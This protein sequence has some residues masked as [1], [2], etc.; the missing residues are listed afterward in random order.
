MPRLAW[1]GLALSTACWAMPARADLGE[2]VRTHQHAR[3]L[4]GRVL[5]LKPRLLERGERLPLP[6]PPELLD[7]K[8]ASCVTV[9][10]LGVPETHFVVRFSSLDPSAPS[11]A[12]PEA[13]VA[14]AMDITRCGSG[15]PFLA[16]IVLEMRSP[17]GVLETLISAAPAGVPRL[18]ETLPGRDPGVDLALGDPG[19]R[20]GLPPLVQ[21][22]AR[23]SA[24][25]KRE[26]ALSFE[27]EPLSARDDGSGAR[28]LS[29]TAGCHQLRLLAE[30]ALP[31]AEPQVD[32][33]LE[34]VNAESGARV[35]VDRSDDPDGALSW[36]VGETVPVELRFVGAR[37][38]SPLTLTHARWE[39]PAGLPQAWG[40]E[41]RAALGRV[42]WAEHLSL[43]S[44]PVYESLGVQGSSALP[45][46]VEPDACYTALLVPLRGEVRALSLSAFVRSPGETARG[47]SDTDGTAVSFCARGATRAT[48]EV[49][50]QGSS[51]SW[52]LALWETG[53]AVI[54]S[55]AP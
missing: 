10:V 32:L 17:R 12:Y 1:L 39:L 13:S 9:A 5:R 21:R 23:L 48:L 27:H 25:A 54:G 45:I 40:A 42:A 22:L 35:A 52:L 8:G 37:P 24:R 55:A 15:K 3:A 14:G 36:C 29:L 2:D 43:P 46:E 11:T 38:S 31:G 26:A 16:G 53:R 44:A 51:L 4:F 20:P 18:Q 50:G 30:T 49:D 6:V 47:A 19:P 33:D 41:P 34:L 7:P 28:A